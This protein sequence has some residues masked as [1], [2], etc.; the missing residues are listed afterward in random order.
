MESRHERRRIT[1]GSGLEPGDPRTQP[2]TLPKRVDCRFL[3][4]WHGNPPTKSCVRDLM[5]FSS[6][7]WIRNF[8]VYHPSRLET[9]RL[10]GAA[11]AVDADS[12]ANAPAPPPDVPIP[13]ARVRNRKRHAR[14]A[15]V[16]PPSRRHV[17]SPQSLV[18]GSHSSPSLV[19]A[20]PPAAKKPRM[21]AVPL[22]SLSPLLARM[23]ALS[24]AVSPL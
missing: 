2:Q 3:A 24:A 7:T 17:C 21:S 5:R 12:R 23:R 14:R 13:G 1:R 10:F 4:R 8:F 15:N 18:E 20:P 16:T 22:A 11:L 9:R 19:A 6:D